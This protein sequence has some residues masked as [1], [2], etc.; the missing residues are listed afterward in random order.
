MDGDISLKGE[1]IRQQNGITNGYGDEKVSYIKF[2]LVSAEEMKE[3][4]LTFNADGVNTLNV[5][6]V[7]EIVS[8]TENWNDMQDITAKKLYSE[9][10][11][12]AKKITVDVTD[13]IK[14]LNGESVFEIK[15]AE[16][17]GKIVYD[18]DFEKMTEIVKETDF[19]QGGQT[20]L[21]VAITTEKAKDGDHALKLSGFNISYGRLKLFNALKSTPL[22]TSDIGRKFRVKH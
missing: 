16:K 18:N 13:Y 4:T 3:A 11:N 6:G 7:K 8:G 21:G 20:S 17:R 1:I 15:S 2:P 19:R 9:V 5:S 14:S 12:G 10:I 22:N